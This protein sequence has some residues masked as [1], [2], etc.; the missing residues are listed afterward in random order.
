VR[1]A[2]VVLLVA[3]A[4]SPK[5]AGY[6]YEVE[7]LAELPPPPATFRWALEPLSCDAGA[8]RSTVDTCSSHDAFDQFLIAA[9]APVDD[10]VSNVAVLRYD[11]PA[12]G[13]PLRWQQQ[14]DLGIEPHSAVVT[15]VRDAAIV[16]A[17]SHG[18][19]RLVA[20]DNVSGRMLGQ[21]TIVEKGAR[22][23]QVEAA[24][25]FARIH[26]RT[27]Q[28]GVVAV[29][30]PRTARVLARRE[31]EEKSIREDTVGPEMKGMDLADN[32][33]AKSGD[34]A[35]DWEAH[36]LVLRRGDQWMRY[37]RMVTEDTERMFHRVTLRR[38][39]GMVLV[40]VHDT[41]EGKIEVFAYEHDGG[42]LIWRSGVTQA[43]MNALV[44]TS[45]DE[46]ELVV[47]GNTSTNS[48]VCSFG[49]ADG[50][51]RACV[52]RLEPPRAT[53]FDF[54]DDPIVTP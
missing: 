17:I 45:V 13:A 26:V 52:D 38:R 21:A 10:T 53:V 27:A 19:A 3:C 8:M 34:I 32:T 4:N 39:G 40:T 33:E 47:H 28:G 22:A 23:V 7:E 43:F 48:F 15:V 41:E 37:L 24:N 50:V 44:G 16:A 14:V 1:F 36:R 5:P 2:V 35:I 49:I 11:G 30:H 20:I 6:R 31:I 9:F 42:K 29:V 25:D 46:D 18:S 54:G 51:E 12:I